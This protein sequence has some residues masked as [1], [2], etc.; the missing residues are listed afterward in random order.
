MITKIGG[1]LLGI[2][3]ILA[4]LWG[5]IGALLPGIALGED[6]DYFTIAVLPDT[7][8]YSVSYPT[9]F[10][11]QAQWIVDNAQAQNI[12]F[13]CQLG[14]IVDNYNVTSQ[15]GNA[16]HS[17]GIIRDA[18]I[19]YSMVPGNHDLNGS[20]GDTSFFDSN[21]PYTDF[22]GYSWYGGNYPSNSNSSNYELISAMQQDFVILNL[23]CTPQLLSNATGWAN[24]ILTQYSDRKAIVVTHGYID[25]QG[26]YSD[27]YDTSGIEIWNNIVKIHS[28][29]IAVFCGHTCPQFYNWDVGSGGNRVYNLLTDYQQL[30]NGGNGYLRLYKFY[31]QLNKISAFT[32]SPYLNQYDNSTG[33]KGGRFDMTLEMES[34]ITAL[35]VSPT[36]G[37][38]NETVDL[39][40]TLTSSGS[41]LSGKNITFAI[42][43]A[44]VGNAT[45]NSAGL[46]MLTGVS[47]AGISAGTHPGYIVASFAG[48]A[49]YSACSGTA[50]LTVNG[51]S[52]S[53]IVFTTPAQTITT[54]A[55]SRAITI[56]SQDSYG[57]PTNVGTNTAI[58]LSSSSVKGAFYSDSRGTRRITSV[59]IRSGTSSA[60]FYYKD[61]QAG[62]PTITADKPGWTGANQQET[63]NAASISKIVF[64]TPAQT[65]KAGA[66]SSVMTIQTQDSYG[67][68]VSV[69]SNTIINLSSSS[70]NGRFYSDAG[71]TNRI[72]SVT[73]SSG[74]NSA[75]FYYKDTRVGTPTITAAKSGWYS[76]TQREK[77]T[78]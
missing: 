22:S 45:T 38:Y 25:A 74:T 30:A 29:V 53:K 70:M 65:V 4:V 15:W 43:G 37:T 12:V 68:P 52:V 28:N 54:G 71:G 57:N 56:Q 6:T 73:I 48:D 61:T 69:K 58:N 55:V 17:M 60:S 19:P 46:A 3:L 23:A 2:L 1:K 9:I 76:A 27:I 24:G 47:I 31:P 67:N 72:T 39:S 7:Q 41:P 75:S 62:T 36:S 33:S 35:S 78:Q 21:F 44:N 66:V 16:K 13:V 63:I 20:A 50:D 26:K 49:D 59:T 5:A 18:G 51:V 42:N 77:I 40:A 14:D 8:H 10:D 32:Y 11:Q 34:S 64:T